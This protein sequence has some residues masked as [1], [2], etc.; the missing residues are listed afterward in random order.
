MSVLR[1]R[2]E[3]L[4][5][6]ICAELVTGRAPWWNAVALQ[7]PCVLGR[8]G[9][10]LRGLAAVVAW[11]TGTKWPEAPLAWRLVPETH[12][13]VER[14][15]VFELPAHG[16]TAL[17]AAVPDRT[18]KR[19]IDGPD[20]SARRLPLGELEIDLAAL[21]G[22][23]NDAQRFK[24][25][26]KAIASLAS[27]F[28]R[29]L[30][31]TRSVVPIWLGGGRWPRERLAHVAAWAQLLADRQRYPAQRPPD[32]P[33]LPPSA[34]PRR[35]KKAGSVE[36]WIDVVRR[37][38]IIASGLPAELREKVDADA[39]HRMPES[40]IR[41]DIFATQSLVRAPA[42]GGLQ[43]HLETTSFLELDD[44]APVMRDMNWARPAVLGLALANWFELKPMP[45][46]PGVAWRAVARQL[47]KK[48]VLRSFVLPPW[49]L[50]NAREI[51]D[52]WDKLKRHHRDA[53]WL[54]SAPWP[55]LKD[56]VSSGRW[57]FDK[58]DAWIS[59]WSPRGF[60]GAAAQIPV[61]K[62]PWVRM[63]MLRRRADDRPRTEQDAIA[64]IAASLECPPQ[65]PAIKEAALASKWERHARPKANGTMRWL[66]VPAMP[67]R[68]A[69]RII[70]ALLDARAP[71]SGT[72]TAFYS[73]ASPALHA[74]AH[75]GAT[76]AVRID[77]A[78]FFG[79]IHPWDLEPWL[80]LGRRPAQNLFADWSADGRSALLALMFRHHGQ[81]AYLPQGAPS[82]PAG[83]NL[84]GLKLDRAIVRD[85]TEAFGAGRFSFTRYADD[86]VLSSRHQSDAAFIEK[87]IALLT[88]NVARRKW[89]VRDGKTATWTKHDRGNLSFCGLIVPREPED[90]IQLDR[91]TARRARAALH[92]LRH[93][94]D[95]AAE[96]ETSP[97]AAHGLLAYA[98]ASTGDPRWL[99]YTSRHVLSLA[100]HL[101][102]P[103]YSE[104]FLAGWSDAEEVAPDED[105]R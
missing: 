31:D 75:A 35:V 19:L 42:L 81:H 24:G 77:I 87:A 91:H 50:L 84:A 71:I 13:D 17:Y 104:S 56:L 92:R 72:P 54:H 3:A 48:V 79:S 39:R 9:G 90:P 6:E 96:S 74:R 40:P 100:R 97:A 30:G 59:T 4:L 67:L 103:L 8:V 88:E 76:A 38:Q 47:R 27:A 70:A 46:E 105:S 80:G 28:L 51:A 23:L 66:D 85:A 78:N 89:R 43:K 52:A 16:G 29:P 62:L 98:Y 22:Q 44:V 25:D 10:S 58:L 101:A 57:D 14:A 7:G 95:F 45:S 82:S 20:P 102:G 18:P 33:V 61:Q 99:A 41:K 37:S 1:R 36:S 53:A 94:E 2:Y 64:L 49:P 5:D 69:Q 86:L 68:N 83:A 26:D 11:H 55:E 60:R 15:A 93:R 12:K 34:K 32:H 73:G 21:A 65:W 63:A